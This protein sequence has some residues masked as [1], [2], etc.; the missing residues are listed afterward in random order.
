MDVRMDV[1]ADKHAQPESADDAKAAFIT[2]KKQGSVRVECARGKPTGASAQGQ[3]EREEHWESLIFVYELKPA[4][5]TTL[6]LFIRSFTRGTV[7]HKRE[8]SEYFK[9]IYYKE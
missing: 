3:R 7:G 9:C 1:H 2:P 5:Q 4:E 6:S 8:I